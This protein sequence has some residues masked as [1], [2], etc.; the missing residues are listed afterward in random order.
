MP[1][2]L[3]NTGILSNSISFNNIIHIF[4]AAAG[5]VNKNRTFSHFFCKFETC[6]YT[7]N[8]DDI[9]DRMMEIGIY[10]LT[11]KYGISSNEY[12]RATA[13]GMFK[14]VVAIVLLFGANW[15][16]KKLDEDTLI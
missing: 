2:F 8:C 12:G 15:I 4:I 9:Y 11:L 13:A 14:S 1:L 10:Q 5:K 6:I 7:V 3:I 16:A